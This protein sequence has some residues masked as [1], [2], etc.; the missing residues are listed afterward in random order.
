MRILPCLLLATTTLACTTTAA[1]PDAGARADAST[2]PDATTPDTGASTDAAGRE[3]P[4]YAAAFPQDEVPRLDLVIS[5]SEWARMQADMTDMLG[6][7]GSGSGTPI[8]PGVPGGPG[9]TTPPAEVFAACVDLSVGAACSATVLGTSVTGTCVTYSDGRLVCLPAGGPGGMGGPPTG[10]DGGMGPGVDGGMGPGGGG[11]MGPGGGGGIGD[12]VD[13]IPRT[14][15]YAECTVSYAGRTWSHVGVRY[16]GNS[17]LAQPWMQGVSKLP[18]RLKFDEFEDTYP[19]TNDQ[20]FFGFKSL[21]LSNGAN[22]DAQIRGKLASD[23]FAAAGLPTSATAYYRLY[24]DHGSGPTYFGLYTAAELPSDG[25]FLRTHFGTDDGNLYKP[26]GTGARWQTYDQTS[27]EK[28][29]NEAAAD[30]SDTVALY[31]ALHAD[32][33]DAAAWR[34]GLEARLDV[35]SFLKWLAL[36]TL[37]QDWDQYGAMPHNYYLYADPAHGGRFSW[38]NWDHSLALQANGSAPAL[39]LD[40]VDERWPLIRL[41]LDDPVYAAAY[42]EEVAALADGVFEPTRMEATI[43][44]AHAL[45]APYVAEEQDG[46]RLSTTAA[47][48]TSL[49]A[50]IAHVR[51]RAAAARTYLGR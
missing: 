29:N 12:N 22:D 10:V 6:A 18:L 43:R 25:A 21:S 31:D 40:T 20:R 11:G 5:A 50:M 44:A 51:S 26:D 16:K 37:I 4:D 1:S 45:V 28:E 3:D 24:I 49:D 17:S 34:A 7:A 46:Y 15:V 19:E 32:R 30:F 35:A 9:G 27:L 41:L 39:A 38:I 33:T 13:L 48:T 47:F 42:R 14:P 36:N 23:L 8:G 2:S